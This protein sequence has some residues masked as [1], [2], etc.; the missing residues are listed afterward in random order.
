MRRIKKVLPLLLAMLIS[1][2]MFAQNGAKL[3]EGELFAGS[4]YNAIIPLHWV[5]TGDPTEYHIFRKEG[6]GDFT[7]IATVATGMFSSANY[8][9]E[10]VTA[11]TEY[12]YIIKDQDDVGMTNEYAA[13]CNNTGHSVTIPGWNTT[14]PTIDGVI[15]SGE[16][17]DAVE[18]DITNN[19]RIYTANH[20]SANT[21]AYMKVANDKL[22]IAVKDYNSP[23]LEQNDQV[24]MF[25]DYNN[26][27]LW[28]ESDNDQRYYGLWLENGSGD[29]MTERTSLTGVYP[30]VSFGSGEYQPSELSGWVTEG[31]GYTAFEFA[32]DITGSYL[33]GHTDNFAMLLQALIYEGGESQGL[34]GL[35]SPGGIWKAPSTFFSCTVQYDADEEAPEV[36]SVDGTTAI[37][38]NEMQITL[39]I[40]DESEIQTVYGTY[41]ID[42]GANQNLTMTASKGN[43][44]YIG[45]IPA[46]STDISGI[47]NFYLEDIHGNSTTTT[48][49]YPI[50]WQTDDEAPII[51]PIST[52]NIATETNIPLI[53]T[54][55][56]DNLAGVSE[57]ILFY[58]INDGTEQSIAMSFID[59]IYTA[60]LPD[61]TK[62][63]TAT[64][65]ISATDNADNNS[66]SETFTINW[67]DGD[68]YGHITGQNTGN[69]FGS[70]GEMTMGIVLELDDFE[71]KINKL[72]Y[73]VPEY[74]TPPFSWKIVELNG[75]GSSIEWTDN[76]LVPEQTVTGELVYNASNWTEIDVTT[77]EN[78]TGTVGLVI[79]LEAD[80]YWG[81]DASSTEGISWFK[82]SSSGSWVQLGVGSW[83][84]YPGDWTLK[85]HLYNA[86]GAGIEKV[87]GNKLISYNYPNPCSNYTN[88]YFENAKFSNV[89]ITIFDI[90][91]KEVTVLLNS[92]LQKGNYSINFNT[93]SL[94]AGTYFYNIIIDNETSTKKIT[95]VK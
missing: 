24:M 69:N 17:D 55:V 21:F 42:G 88:I 11:G 14:E 51:S 92:S 28:T 46:E 49:N 20:W 95:V 48:A 85:A 79:E 44:G 12:T 54:E 57:V 71:G 68:W 73:M 62:G 16:W 3:D 2:S 4:G 40:S 37:T 36:I 41:S 89:T 75:N 61:Q 19:V 1:I 67:Y 59:N 81:R 86:E 23:T 8:I 94:P 30:D 38:N 43:Y 66:I 5:E 33:E 90:N 82:E 13:T 25:F 50:E 7:Q 72:A 31:T 52:P 35:F 27:G 32:Y 70:T 87:F 60:S 34:S 63:T 83:S 58:T 45:T 77:D 76:V 56:T 65:Y 18:I 84:D 15:S 91:G 29:L 64:Y 22:Y 39:N 10:N 53:T 6:T 78:I 9:D 47:L 80:S 93:Q 74:F 26:D